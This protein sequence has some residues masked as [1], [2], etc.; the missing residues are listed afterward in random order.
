MATFQISPLEN[1]SFTR[2]EEWPRWIKRFAGTLQTSIRPVRKGRSESS[3]RISFAMVYQAE[4]ILT[5]FRLSEEN[6][7]KY[8]VVKE[9][10]E[11]YFVERLNKIYERAR[12]NQRSQLPG[13]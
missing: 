12:F 2:P 5:L 1:F 11:N 3:E 4:Y 6:G 9:K 13:D 8:T 10:F 7:K